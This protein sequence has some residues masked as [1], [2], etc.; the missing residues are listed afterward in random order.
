MDANVR[1]CNWYGEHRDKKINFIKLKF[2]A[3]IA[4]S[5]GEESMSIHAEN[6]SKRYIWKM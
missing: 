6:V 3:D 2:S 4:I 5:V 1:R